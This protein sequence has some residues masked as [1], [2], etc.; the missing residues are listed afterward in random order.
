[1]IVEI[2]SDKDNHI[3]SLSL[4]ISTIDTTIVCMHIRKIGVR[5]ADI[6]VYIYIHIYIYILQ[7]C[8]HT[9]IYKYTYTRSRKASTY[10]R[11]GCRHIYIY[12]ERE[13]ERER[14]QTY[15]HTHIYTFMYTTYERISTP[16]WNISMRCTHILAYI[17]GNKFR[18]TYI[19]IHTQQLSTQNR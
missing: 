15:I 17:V 12:I 5:T 2:K 10:E 19:H 16:V 1:V 4:L 6:Y 11:A 14:V 8:I 7:T 9:H 18:H 13:R 3:R